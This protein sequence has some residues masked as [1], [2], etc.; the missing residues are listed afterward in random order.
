MEI[1]LNFSILIIIL[2][3]STTSLGILLFIKPSWVY[4]I[5]KSTGKKEISW[6]I[7]SLYSLLFG[8]LAGIFALL[9]CKKYTKPKRKPDKRFSQFAST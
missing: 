8:L 1:S 7:I 6:P 4:K 5:N 3:I 9:Y 2:I